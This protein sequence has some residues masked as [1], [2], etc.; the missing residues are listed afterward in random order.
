MAVGT[1]PMTKNCLQD[2]A[3]SLGEAR[4]LIIQHLQQRKIESKTLEEYGEFIAICKHIEVLRMQME[5]K[6]RTSFSSD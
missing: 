6:A 5:V 4:R 1:A 3:G 2:A